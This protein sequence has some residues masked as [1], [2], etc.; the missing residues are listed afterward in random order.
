M[1]LYVHNDIKLVLTDSACTIVCTGTE[2]DG[3]GGRPGGF[4]P[5]PPGTMTPE[6]VIDI[7]NQY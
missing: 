7:T 5:A 4:L 6:T 1:S 3:C 2:C